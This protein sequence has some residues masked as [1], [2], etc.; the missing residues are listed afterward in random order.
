M[1]S[2]ARTV[3]LCAVL[4]GY[5]AAAALIF[6][7]FEYKQVEESQPNIR[8]MKAILTMEYN[9]SSVDAVE[10]IRQITEA[11]LKDH[12]IEMS[13]SW[14]SFP[15]SLWFVMTLFTTVG[16]G[17]LVPQTFGGR[18]FCM[19]SALFGIPLYALFLKYAGEQIIHILRKLIEVFEM[20]MKRE[21][22]LQIKH[23][24]IKVLMSAFLL[25]TSTILVGA[26]GSFAFKWS[27]F[28]ATYKDAE[29]RLE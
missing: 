1:A 12:T 10:L 8:R 27:Y 16:T 17:H 18:L 7:L 3:I 20:T 24:N 28:E 26:L 13:S 23:M 15:T 2:A 25:M 14:K 6:Q 9:I 4:H 29:Q 19:L 11:N 21:N 5:I 22:P